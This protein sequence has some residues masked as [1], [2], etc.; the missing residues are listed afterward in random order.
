MSTSP[1]LRSN[2]SRHIARKL[3]LAGA[4][5]LRKAQASTAAAVP[6]DRSLSM[7]LVAVSSTIIAT[8]RAGDRQ[9]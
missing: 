6:E 9:W 2:L 7:F 8:S 3:T 1:L 4:V 5:R